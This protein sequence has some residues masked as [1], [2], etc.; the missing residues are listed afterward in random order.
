[1]YVCFLNKII[2]RINTLFILLCFITYFCFS[3]FNLNPEIV[4][5]SYNNVVQNHRWWT[6]ITSQFMHA[7]LLHLGGNVLFMILFGYPLEKI[8]GK[9]KFAVCFLTGGILSF[10]LCYFF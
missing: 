5:Y 8:I 4:G 10:V 1:M 3:Y 7:N 2:M 9:L 6:L